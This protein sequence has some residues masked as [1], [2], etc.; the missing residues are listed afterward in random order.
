MTAIPTVAPAARWHAWRTRR[1]TSPQSRQ[2]LARA[3][4]RLI[5]DA[6]AVSPPLRGSAAPINRDEVERCRGLLEEVATELRDAEAVAPR[7]IALVESLLRDGGSPVYAPDV[8]GALEPTL[9]HARA[10]LLLR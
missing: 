1:L 2:R 10:A 9:R 8:E 7:G 3:I 5:E 6:H 4:E